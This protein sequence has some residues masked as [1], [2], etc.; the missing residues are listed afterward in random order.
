MNNNE[1]MNVRTLMEKVGE[2]TGPMAALQKARLAS[3]LAATLKTAGIGSAIVSI[4][5]NGNN[6]PEPTVSQ[7]IHDQ[8]PLQPVTAKPTRAERY[9][10]EARALLAEGF[11]TKAAQQ[12]AK[13]QVSRAFSDVRDAM[14]NVY[15]NGERN[16]RASAVYHD[17]P[18]YPHEW[19]PRHAAMVRADLPGAAVHLEA[20][21]R[22]VSLAAE[23]KATPILTKIADE[24]AA[25]ERAIALT[26]SLNPALRAEF[27]KQAPEIAADF[28]NYA[29]KTYEILQKK[30]PDGVPSYIESTGRDRQYRN[31]VLF[32]QGMCDITTKL[33]P[34][35]I[36]GASDR[37]STMTINEV[38]LKASAEKYGM[39]SALEWFYKTNGK[40]GELTHATLIN[41][42]GGRVHVKGERNGKKIEIVQQ[43]IINVSPLGKAF[44][45]F[46]SRIYVEGKFVTE[47]AYQKL[48]R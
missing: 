27:E 15:L 31:D 12:R 38:L 41:D 17:L 6:P 18:S 10:S 19:K 46:P 24:K 29:R 26:Q 9:E 32:L 28:E 16:P 21:E 5:N 35:G 37:I 14:Q 34:S 42:D 47:L 45:Q 11:T 13:E 30:F 20:I 8:S 25:K 43:R 33:G 3:Q 2:Q 1:R 44:H 7:S 4:Y 23:I 39:E 22:L 40:L 48:F 36:R